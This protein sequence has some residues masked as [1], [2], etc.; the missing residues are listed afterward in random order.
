MASFASVLAL[1]DR[2]NSLSRIDAILINAGV[3]C[4]T[5]EMAEQ[6]DTQVTVNVVSAFIL[7]IALLPK[8]QDSAQRHGIQLTISMT[9]AFNHAFADASMLTSPADGEI[10]AFL[11]SPRAKEKDDM[12]ARYNVTKLLVILLVRELAS[13]LSATSPNDTKTPSVITSNVAPSW[14]RIS[15]DLVGESLPFRAGLKMLGWTR[16]EGSRTLAHA[17]S[18]G[19]GS[20]GQYLNESMIKSSSAF[21]SDQERCD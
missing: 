20:H 21:V 3:Q 19:E 9:G 8:L 18:A 17:V 12:M 1:A 11:N 7:A 4:E 13:K 10:F 5:F 6:D 16:E 2:C 15:M 14:C